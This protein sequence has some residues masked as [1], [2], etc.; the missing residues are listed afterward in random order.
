MARQSLIERTAE[1]NVEYYDAS[2]TEELVS[3][4]CVSE[5]VVE[6][7]SITGEWD[8]LG[9][10]REFAQKPV[11]EIIDDANLV[12]PEDLYDS[13]QEFSTVCSSCWDNEG[14]VFRVK[15]REDADGDLKSLVVPIGSSISKDFTVQEIHNDDGEFVAGHIEEQVD[16][17]MYELWR[18]EMYVRD[19]SGDTDVLI[20]LEKDYANHISES[21]SNLTDIE[22]GILDQDSTLEWS[23]KT[24]ML[25]YLVGLTGFLAY[26]LYIWATSL[27]TTRVVLVIISLA[28]F[29][30]VS[31]VLL[32]QLS[33]GISGAKKAINKKRGKQYEK[34][35]ATR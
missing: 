25:L 31:A 3:E 26:N 24:T 11:D 14:E 4:L 12:I 21:I 28:V 8:K 33:L 32:Y 30:L 10:A 7:R 20:K 34:L 2:E 27:V 22:D 6:F 23:V 15:C 13:L 19:L 35:F 18:E 29:A 1:K 17:E 9:D 5:G 16:F